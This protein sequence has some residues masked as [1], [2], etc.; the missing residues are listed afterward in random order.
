MFRPGVKRCR[1]PMPMV[2][3]NASVSIEDITGKKESLWRK[4][5]YAPHSNFV[6]TMA[7]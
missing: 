7:T 5:F 2:T 3:T 4:Y 1:Y 6:T